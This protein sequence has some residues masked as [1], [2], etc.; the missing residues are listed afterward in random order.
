VSLRLPEAG[1]ASKRLGGS[2]WIL[3][4][5]LLSNYPTL[6]HKE[7]LVTHKIP[8]GT[9]PQTLNFAKAR[10][11]SQRVV[12]LTRQKWMLSVI[13]WTVVLAAKLTVLAAVDVWRLLHWATASVLAKTDRPLLIKFHQNN[14]KVD[15][16]LFCL[17]SDVIMW[18]W[19]CYFVFNCVHA[20]QVRNA[21]CGNSAGKYCMYEG[22]PKSFWPHI[23]RNTP[24]Y[25]YNN[26]DQFIFLHNLRKLQSTY[27]SVPVA[28]VF[29][30]YRRVHRAIF[31]PEESPP[32]TQLNSTQQRTTDAGVWHL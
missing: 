21:L 29:Q 23:H 12:N 32:Q 11:S 22:C 8:A 16:P 26:C 13:N 14:Q 1:I 6:C 7:I 19:L 31:V 4:W 10:R 27:S 9:L 2:S 18:W 28:A 15:R 17:H 24:Q 3:S 5:S 20:F 25:S 30:S